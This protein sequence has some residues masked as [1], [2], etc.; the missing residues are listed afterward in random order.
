VDVHVQRLRRKLED[1]PHAPQ[2]L[3]TVHSIGY[4]FAADR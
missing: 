4:K 3:L 2:Y 1:D